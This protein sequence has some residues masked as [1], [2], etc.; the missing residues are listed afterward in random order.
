MSDRYYPR[1]QKDITEQ[2]NNPCPC[3]A[4]NLDSKYTPNEGRSKAVIICR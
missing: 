4:Y 2:K 1:H 3:E